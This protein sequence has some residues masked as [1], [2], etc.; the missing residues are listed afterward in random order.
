LQAL[1]DNII[2]ITSTIILVT[3]ILI[4]KYNDVSRK[5]ILYINS[6]ALCQIH[7]INKQKCQIEVDYYGENKNF[8]HIKISEPPRLITS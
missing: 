5:A 3:V 4:I 6:E 7:G 1:K 2:I 8:Y